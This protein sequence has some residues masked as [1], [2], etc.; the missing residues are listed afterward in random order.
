[1]SEDHI[2]ELL[3]VNFVN[4]VALV[5]SISD[6]ETSVRIFSCIAA[7]LY[8]IAKLIQTVQEIVEKRK[9]KNERP[10]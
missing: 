7:G 3:K 2:G 8:T 9:K 5:V 6:F 10:E 4:I 1:M